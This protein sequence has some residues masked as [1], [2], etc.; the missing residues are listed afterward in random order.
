MANA[1]AAMAEPKVRK[2]YEKL[3]V[4]QHKRPWDWENLYFG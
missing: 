3:T 1:G 2:V 4:K